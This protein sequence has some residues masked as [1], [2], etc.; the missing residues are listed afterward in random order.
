MSVQSEIDRIITT[1][2]NA[3]SKVSEKGGTVPASQTVANLATAIDS[4]PAGGGASIDAASGSSLPATVVNDQVYII[5]STTPGTIYIDTD[6]PSSP[7]S[8]DAWVVVAEGGAGAIAFTEDSPLFRVGFKAVKQYGSNGKWSNVEAYLGAS[9]A[10]VRISVSL[11]SAGTLLNNFTWAQ[12]DYISEN[13]FVSDYFNIGD[14]KNVTIGSATYVVEI[15]GFSH[16]DKADGSG[17]AGLTFGLKD[18]LNTTYRMNSSNTNAGGWGSCALRATLRGDIW[19]QLPS[20]LRGVIKEVTKKAS[21]GNL[22]SIISSYTDT[23]FLFAENEIFGNTQYS[24][25]GEGTQ[26]ARFTT[27]NTRIKR[28]NGSATNW[29]LRSPYSGADISFC[30]VLSGGKAGSYAASSSLGVAFGFCV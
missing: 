20:D 11:P 8:G 12:I 22:S 26:Y 2:G 23:L 16:D 6:M 28:L 9:G 19:N 27:S 4:I 1:V 30:R 5:T 18:C 25:N 7:A 15:V 14:I 13:G 10:W 21:A 17:K 3:Y 29:W 24:V